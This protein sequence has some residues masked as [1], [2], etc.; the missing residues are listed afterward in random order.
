MGTCYQV[1]TSGNRLR[2][3][4]VEISNSVNTIFIV[5]TCEGVNK[6]IYQSQLHL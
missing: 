6:S 3:L 5:T 2:R 1:K 4:S